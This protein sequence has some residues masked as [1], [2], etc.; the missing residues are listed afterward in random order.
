MDLIRFTLEVGN[1][2][3]N[4]YSQT[5]CLY[6]LRHIYPLTD[7]FTKPFQ[8]CFSIE[9][10]K[11]IWILWDNSWSVG[12]STFKDKVKPFLKELIQNPQLNV[13]PDGTNLGILTFSTQVQTKVLR[14]MHEDQNPSA[15]LSF[16]DSLKY[17][18]VAGD[19]TRTGMALREASRVRARFL[20]FLKFLK[21]TGGGGHAYSRL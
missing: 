21:L 10:K 3:L 2:T 6:I 5:L 15:L 19:G 8:S 12:E 7:Q 18:D 17:D 16:L 1:F 14:G 4:L 9:C 20:L 13:G 11:D